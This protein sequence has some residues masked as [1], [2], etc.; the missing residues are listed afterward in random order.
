MTVQQIVLLHDK[1]NPA[2]H[3]DSI[4]AA[5]AA[6]VR[7]YEISLASGGNMA[8]WQAWM[9]DF[10]A[11]S[12]RRAKPS[13]FA[14]L[15]ES[16]AG[17]MRAGLAAAAAFDPEDP[18]ALSPA[19]ARLQVSGTQMPRTH[20]TL[21]SGPGPTIM[22]NGA[23]GMSTGKAAAQ[24]AHSLMDWYLALSPERRAAWAGAGYG[25]R[26]LEASGH[27]FAEK[28]A[29]AVPHTVVEDQGRTEIEPGSLTAYVRGA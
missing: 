28:L 9:D 29:T 21:P 15:T 27:R 11:K 5:A 2:T 24:A 7:A 22:I 4:A 12:V 3:L 13:V 17:V 20:A 19:V 23:L 14:G 6:S 1:A 8:A 26:V 16:H 10:H 25:V 18:A